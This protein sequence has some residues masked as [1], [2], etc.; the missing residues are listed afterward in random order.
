MK[1]TIKIISL[2]LLA[3]FSLSLFSCDLD[4]SKHHLSGGEL[5]DAGRMSEIKEEILTEE[6]TERTKEQAENTTETE[7]DDGT[8]VY[9]TESGNVWHKSASCTHIKNSANLFA[10]TVTRAIESGKSAACTKCF[11]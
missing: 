2:I 7:T 9:W 6:S 8:I 10:G 4:E 1:S 3:F 5:L 11:D